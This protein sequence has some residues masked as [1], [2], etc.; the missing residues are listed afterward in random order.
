MNPVLFITVHPCDE[1]RAQKWGT[2]LAL[3]L[4]DQAV[5]CVSTDPNMWAAEI[6]LQA[7]DISAA[8]RELA[9]IAPGWYVNLHHSVTRVTV[10]IRM[11]P[12]AGSAEQRCLM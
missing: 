3:R 6:H 4:Y 8:E 11:S 12:S 5:V 2:D 7:P 1:E 9:R 10:T